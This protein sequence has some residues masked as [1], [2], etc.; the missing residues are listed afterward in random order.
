MSDSPY[1]VHLDASNL[2]DVLVE[3]SKKQPV[4]VD[5]WA[6]WC[7][8]CLHLMPILERLVDEYNGAFILAKLDAV[9]NEDIVAQ[10]G[11]RGFPT[12]RL[13]KDGQAIDEFSGALPEGDIRTFLDQHVTAAAAPEGAD[14]TETAPPVDA[15][16]MQAMALAESGDSAAAKEVLKSAQAD[17]PSNTE[18]LLLLGQLSVADNELDAARG[19]L[20]AMTEEARDEPEP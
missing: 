12:C 11:V 6:D 20:Q 15:P 18:I 2:M 4:L 14:L 16:V 17:D 19:C 9:A 7:Q 8:P 5:I 13:F 1:I 10:M 3:G